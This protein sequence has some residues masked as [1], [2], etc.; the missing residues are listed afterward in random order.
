MDVPTTEGAPGRRARR[1]GRRSRSAT[2]AVLV[3]ALVATVVSV[4]G[5]PATDVAEAAVGSDFDPSY[6]ISDSNFYDGTSM[7][8]D[9]I[10]S[11]LVSRGSASCTGA[12]CLKNLSLSS[13]SRAA[14]GVCRAY[15][16]GRLRFADVLARVSTACGINPKV[17]LVTLEKEQSLITTATTPTRARLDRA[18]GYGCPDTAPCDPAFQGL[19]R[20][21][22]AAARQFKNYSVASDFFTWFPVGRP[23]AVAYQANAPQCGSSQVVIKNAATA[24]LYYYTPYQPNA[25]A[26]RNLYGTGDGC[27][28]YGNRNFWRLFSDWFGSPIG[29]VD[30]RGRLDSVVARGGPGKAR[31][32][33]WAADPDT[34]SPINVHVYVDGRAV[35]SVRA[36][37]Y[38]GDIGRI[39]PSWGPSHG[40]DVE[41][42]GIAAGRHEV[43]VYGIN[44]SY[45]KNVRLGCSSVTMP[46]APEGRLDAV[47]ASGPGAVG[48]SG[49]ALDPETDEPISV[50]VYVD[51]GWKASVRADG[52]RPDVAR[53]R[54]GWSASRG[55]ASTITGLSGGRHEVCAYGINVGQGRNVQLG[56][57]TVELPGGVPSGRLDEA[58]SSSAGTIDARGWAI[59]PDTANSIQVHVYV[60]GTH[61]SS[62]LASADRPDVARAR[63]GYGAAHGFTT[64]ITGVATGAHTV[65]AYGINVGVGKN[66]K[67]GSCRTVS[68]R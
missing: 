12:T 61:R 58:T 62:V 40:F 19:D 31:V 23:V 24:A 16:G 53:A 29:D 2:A 63:P 52:A 34:A 7:T 8:G 43:C 60:D 30:P 18:L 36:D 28:A 35:R 39:Y 59:D 48:L 33:G 64:R 42:D 11:F 54:P 32:T 15:Q 3:A 47:T 6:I 1:S 57:R 14:D 50:H 55:Y 9:Q 65:C 68:V 25:A 66:V 41:I 26:L 22:Y 17:L 49:W 46:S 45:G 67:V 5:P 20:Q 4:L 10:Q 44:A 56:C 27:S 13:A 38:R 21:V 37:T 51:G